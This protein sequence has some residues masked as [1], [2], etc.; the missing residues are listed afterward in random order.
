[1]IAEGVAGGVIE[2]GPFGVVSAEVGDEA[3]GDLAGFGGAFFGGKFPF[4]RCAG[5]A[6]TAGFFGAANEAEVAIEFGEGFA[7]GKVVDGVEDGGGV[8]VGEW[9]AVGEEEFGG[10]VGELFGG[11]DEAIDKA[12][13]TAGGAGLEFGK[14][15]F[16][17]FF[18]V[19]VAGGVF[20]LA[21]FD[22][23]KEGVAELGLKAIL[24]ALVM[25]VDAFDAVGLFGGD[26]FEFVFAHVLRSCGLG[27]TRMSR[28][29]SAAADGAAERM[30]PGPVVTW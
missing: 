9:F 21:E 1:L 18:E 8:F 13:V 11:G 16:L 15:A 10:E 30:R 12:H 24:T 3:E 29:K 27:L 6:G 17:E 22:A 25:D 28:M 7:I 26:C 5:G 20:E 23:G 4:R 19:A 2:T 14:V